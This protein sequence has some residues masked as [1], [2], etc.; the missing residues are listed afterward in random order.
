MYINMQG[1]KTAKT[2]SYPTFYNDLVIFPSLLQYIIL[3]Y[4]LLLT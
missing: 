2:E 3:I 4:R 1:I